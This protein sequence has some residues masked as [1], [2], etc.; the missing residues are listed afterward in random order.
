MKITYTLD[1]LPNERVIQTVPR[2]AARVEEWWYRRPHIY[3]GR[4]LTDK[5]L[6]Q[7]AKHHIQHLQLFGEIFMN[8]FR[9]TQY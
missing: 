3:R 9:F 1:R 7:N 6:I 8:L 2:M 5:T 4:A